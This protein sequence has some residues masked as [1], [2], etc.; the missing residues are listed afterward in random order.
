MTIEL[1]FLDAAR[2]VLAEFGRDATWT[3]F[4]ASYAAATGINT[5]TPTIHA[6]TCT[7]VIARKQSFRPGETATAGDGVIYIGAEGLTFAPAAGDTVT[8]D[9]QWTV[10]ALE[11]I[12]AKST[13]VLY[14][15]TV[16]KGARA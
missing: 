1:D 5:L 10:I 14:S 3:K 12:A 7:P 13:P 9:E 15:A 4:A 11:T 8:L 6:V 2:A 16:R